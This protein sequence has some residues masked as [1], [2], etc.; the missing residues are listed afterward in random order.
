[1]RDSRIRRVGLVALVTF[2]A[3]MA[4]AETPL[5]KN[6]PLETDHFA[7]LIGTWE[8]HGRQLQSDGRTWKKTEHPGE[9]R[10]YRILAG[11][12]IQDD[13][14]QPAPDIDVPEGERGYGTNI[15]IYNSAKQRWEMAWIH[16][17]AREAWEFTAVSHPGEIVMSSIDLDP[18]RRNT[19]HE[20]TADSFA[21]RQDRS[22]DGG[23]T[24]IPV[25]YLEASRKGPV[26]SDREADSDGGR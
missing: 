16:S 5:H 18:P 11:H 17:D 24:W 4:F 8:V 25:S 19:F 14:V 26:S 9:W 23:K 21:W 10:F 7:P 3:S 1:M 12:A 2:A 13:W 22:F 6:A 15:R 20:I